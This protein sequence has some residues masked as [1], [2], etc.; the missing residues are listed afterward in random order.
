[1]PRYIVPISINKY[2]YYADR[3]LVDSWFKFDFVLQHSESEDLREK[4][5]VEPRTLSPVT[6][7]H[8]LSQ[9]TSGKSPRRYLIGSLAKNRKNWFDNF[10]KGY[11][12][13]HSI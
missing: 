11:S 1:M 3:D 2:R 7:F 8:E 13:G 4:W 6:P 10:S 12:G 9:F 5:P